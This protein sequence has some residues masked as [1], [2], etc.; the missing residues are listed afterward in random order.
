MTID[1]RP[2][3]PAPVRPAAPADLAPVRPAAPAATAAPAAPVQRADH[4]APVRPAAPA[5][6]APVHRPHRT[7]DAPNPKRT[8]AP[9]RRRP[10]PVHRGRLALVL[11]TGTTTGT[12]TGAALAAG[13]V[14]LP[15]PAGAW[16]TVA[17]IAAALAGAVLAHPCHRAARALAH[18]ATRTA[19]TTVRTVSHRVAR[20]GAPVHHAPAH[21]GSAPVRPRTNPA[22]VQRTSADDTPRTT[23]AAPV[24]PA[25]A[26]TAAP[27][28]QPRTGAPTA[29]VH[30]APTAPVQAPTAP[31]Q[32]P[33]A[34]VQA[35]AAPVQAP[36]APV[37]AGVADQWGRL[38][39]NR[40]PWFRRGLAVLGA[41]IA[42]ALVGVVVAPPALS[43]DHIIEWAR[44]DSTDAGLGLSLRWAWFVFLALDVTAGVCVLVMLLCALIDEPAGL[45][46]IYVWGFAAATAYANYSYGTRPGAAGDEAWF[47]PTMSLVG[48]LVL[49]SVLKL[50]TRIIRAQAGGK[51]AKR[52]TFGAIDWLPLVGTPQETFG[53]WRVGGRL[54]IETADAAR[55]AYRILTAGRGWWGRWSVDGPIRSQQARALDA[56]RGPVYLPGLLPD[57]IEQL[58]APAAIAAPPA[59]APVDVL[60]ALAPAPAAAPAPAPRPVAPPAPAP[61]DAK[62]TPTRPATPPAPAPAR[63]TTPAP[64]AP[65][66]GTV[67]PLNTDDS[68]RAALAALAA[69]FPGLGSWEN[70]RAA[71][72]DPE[73]RTVTQSR[74][75]RELRIGKRR[76]LRVLDRTDLHPYP[77]PTTSTEAT[78]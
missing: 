25:P 5:D 65:E 71:L 30:L 68:D 57:G 47:F 45:F 60:P 73:D 3:A 78:A 46:T 61:V 23:P 24:Q 53:A 21:Q 14:T 4:P 13:D 74:I 72:H 38:T 51:K 2:G 55:I 43:A 70:L 32:A 15:Y 41:L 36:A 16:A 52:P 7:G 9:V 39:Y 76:L 75:E 6:P 69:H 40:G 35:P 33:A 67:T 63:P 42:V 34:P 59:P 62:P 22:P 17:T 28:H 11:A 27:A 8:S 77:A 12:A 20:T 1:T 26:R 48:P 44:T 31:V 18:R 56:V 54:G 10:A 29:P 66:A 37:R 49:H 19:R 58:T 64:E 50:V